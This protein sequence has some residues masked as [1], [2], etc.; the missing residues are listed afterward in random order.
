MK[1]Y[2]YWRSSASWRVR[3][4]LHWK[5]IPFEYV[6]VHLVRDGGEQFQPEHLARNP[7]AQVPVLELDASQGHPIRFL[8]QSLAILEYL[9]ELQPAPP[10]LPRSLPLRARARQLAEL[11]NSGIQPMQN[12][13]LLNQIKGEYHADERAFARAYIERGLGAF[14]TLLPET[15]GRYCVGDEVS[16]AD[17]C[18]VP[19]LNAARRFGVALDGALQPL[20]E[21]EARLATLPAF[22]GAHADAQPDAQ[23]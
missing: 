22:A 23:P 1:L 2:N 16:F 18:L 9:E 14:A 4:G 19:Q 10:L 8:A 17:V 21:I 13:R 12:P 6:P 20:V 5:G 11:V 3:I 15:A 7:I